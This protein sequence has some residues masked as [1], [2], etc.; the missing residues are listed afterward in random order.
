MDTILRVMKIVNRI[1]NI[2]RAFLPSLYFNFKYLP[3]KQSIRLPIIV[4]K[5]DFK[6]VRGGIKI[7]SDKIHTGM[8]ALGLR[9]TSLFQNNGFMWNVEGQIVFKGTCSIGNDSYILCG[10]SGKIVFGNNF[11]ATGGFRLCSYSNITFGEDVL[12]GWGSTIL[13]TDF[14][15]LFDMATSEYKKAYGDVNIGNANWFACF[16]TVLHSVTTSDNCVF[17][18]HS[19][20]TRSQR[21]SPNSLYVGNPARYVRNDVRLD[22]KKRNIDYPCEHEK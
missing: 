21:Y 19:L 16:C 4:Y 6:C 11:V 22:V 18:A 9:T 13:D 20:I 10:K 2:I 8:I 7:E 5:P 12:V 3:F 17:G 15:P 1:I 14:H